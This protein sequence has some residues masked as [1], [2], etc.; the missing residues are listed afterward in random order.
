M[1]N[2]ERKNSP[3]NVHLYIITSVKI[4][5]FNELRDWAILVNQNQKISAQTLK[6]AV[7]GVFS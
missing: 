1:E 3:G 4:Y 7:P 2:S 6:Q 5:S